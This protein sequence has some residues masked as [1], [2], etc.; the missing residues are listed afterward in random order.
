M[1][2]VTTFLRLIRD[3][4]KSLMA[5]F[6]RRYG[7][8]LSD[9]VF[10]SLIYKYRFGKSLNWKNPQTFNEKL[11]W[12]KLYDRKPEYT[13][14]VDK[15]LVKEYVSN[16]IGD[17]YIIPTI[18]VWDSPSDIDWDS[19]PMQF[20][21]KTTHGGG[22]SGVIVVKNKKLVSKN[23]IVAKLKNAMK[24]DIYQSLREW[25]YK[26]VEKRIIA[27]QYLEDADY[28]ELRDYKFFCFDGVVKALFVATERNTG[29]VKFDYFDADFNHLDIVQSHPM[30]GRNIDKPVCFDEMKVI[31]AKL[32]KG[33]PQVRID[34]YEVNGK[35]YFGEMTFSH[36][37]GITPFH[38]ESWDYILGSWIKLPK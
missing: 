4:R 28:K 11:N 31:S 13:R 20:V 26:N 34:L 19:L 5:T 14:M 3:D 10:L 21:L 27:E 23:D 30:S 9:K 32:S 25:P 15:Y 7:C 33:I 17:S 38:P 12:L 18:G 36:H 6:I 2:R 35:V 1:S 8:W 16:I 29:N 37:G 22:N 24:Q